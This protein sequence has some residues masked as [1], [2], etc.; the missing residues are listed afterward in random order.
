MPGD[1]YRPS[2]LTWISDCLRQLGQIKIESEKYGMSMNFDISNVQA[3][4][5]EHARDCDSLACCVH[6]GIGICLIVVRG[7]CC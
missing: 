2:L 5:F 6:I 3:N 7:A 4:R 1:L